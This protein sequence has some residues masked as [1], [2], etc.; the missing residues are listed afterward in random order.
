MFDKVWQDGLSNLLLL[1]KQILFE[2]DKRKTVRYNRYERKVC[3]SFRSGC[4]HI[5]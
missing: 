3:L 5:A 2:D 4:I 1:Y